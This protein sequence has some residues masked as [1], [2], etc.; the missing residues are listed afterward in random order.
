MKSTGKA[1][2]TGLVILFIMGVAVNSWCQAPKPEEMPTTIEVNWTWDFLPG[3]DKKAYAEFTKKAVAGL[4]KAPGLIEFR[5][6]RNVLGSPQ[7]RAT[8]VW[9]SLTDW[10]NYGGTKEWQEMEAELRTF[11]TNIHVEIWGPTPLV[12]KPV[13]PGK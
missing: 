7:A 10:A 6:N 2:L 5:A 8:S 4:M 1:L 12:P 9:R 11:V 3:M 13:R